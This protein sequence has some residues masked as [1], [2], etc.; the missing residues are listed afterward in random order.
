MTVFE[1]MTDFLLTSVQLYIPSDLEPDN[2][3]L[4]RFYTEKAWGTCIVGCITNFV[5]L[6]FMRE[7]RCID[8]RFL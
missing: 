8:F 2:P 5:G 3:H 6:I 1:L 7:S 4:K